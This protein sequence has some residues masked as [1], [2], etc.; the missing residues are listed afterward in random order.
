MLWVLD[1]VLDDCI[2]LVGCFVSGLFCGFW[3]VLCVLR[4]LRVDLLGGLRNGVKAWGGG[5]GYEVWG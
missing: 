3:E 4:D 1:C 2:C 5:I